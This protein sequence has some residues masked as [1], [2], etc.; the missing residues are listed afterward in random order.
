[1]KDVEALKQLLFNIYGAVSGASAFDKILPL[2]Q[3]FEKKKTVPAPLFSEDQ[4]VLITY[5][6]SLVSIE[7]ETSPLKML[8]TFAAQYFSDVFSA[9]HILPFFPY[10]SDDGFS[11]KDFF[12]VDPNLGTWE[13]VRHLNEDFELMFDY[14]LNHISAQSQWFKDYLAGKAHAA[15]LAIEVDKETDL[16]MVTRPRALPL[17]TEFKKDNGRTVHVWTTFSAD[18]IDL[19]YKSLE[20]LYKMVSVLLYYVQN[21]ATILRLDAIA[22]LW[23]EMGTPCIHLPQTHEF[24][25]LLRKILDIAAPSVL[26]LTETNVPHAENVSYFGN[27][28]DEAQIVY[29]FTLPPL[30]LYSFLKQDTTRLTQWAKTLKLEGKSN[31]FFNFTASHDGIGVRPLEGILPK[32][33]IDW[34][35]QKVIDNQGHISYRQNPDGTQSPYELNITYVSAMADNSEPDQMNQ[36][37]RFLASQAVQYALPG[38]PATYVHSVLGSQ[39][40]HEGVTRTNRFRT[41]NREK[42]DVQNIIKDLKAPETFRSRIF[43]PYLKLITTRRRQPAFHPK[44][45]FEVHNLGPKIFAF[46]RY[47]DDQQIFAITNMSSE[48]LGVSLP[49][50]AGT[51]RMEDLISGEVYDPRNL[52]LDPYAYVWLSAKEK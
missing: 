7:K 27:G 38:I 20:V 46:K 51:G 11:V 39:N 10:S 35:A 43:F 26:I 15:D 50:G 2:I 18:Q 17:L 5:A 6:D 32:T 3:S 37:K 42:L 24:V 28:E 29:N 44:S 14:V 12:A 4:V 23:K 52:T 8:H 41:I 47:S 34:L 49:A 36:V 31:T 48:S 30:L 22:Y 19:N 9:I 1:M 40:W 33:E 13:D 45:G 21:G 25:K 16:S